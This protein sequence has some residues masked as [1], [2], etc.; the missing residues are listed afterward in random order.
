M[1]P[2]DLESPRKNAHDHTR[3]VHIRLYPICHENAPPYTL[4]CTSQSCYPCYSRENCNAVYGNSQST[5]RLY[6]K[7]TSFGQRWE[8]GCHGGRGVG[9]MKI[10]LQYQ[11]ASIRQQGGGIRW[12]KLRM[13]LYG[14]LGMLWV[15]MVSR[16]VII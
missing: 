10:V 5:S 12:C 9:G 11:A 13:A 1:G 3:N 7:D 16:H 14:N 15:H 6:Y 8:Q 4:G 2:P